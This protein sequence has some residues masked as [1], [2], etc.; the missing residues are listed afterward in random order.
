MRMKKKLAKIALVVAVVL[1][2]AA[3]ASAVSFCDIPGNMLSAEYRF[4]QQ[5]VC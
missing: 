1:A 2:A 3:P 4:L 5:L